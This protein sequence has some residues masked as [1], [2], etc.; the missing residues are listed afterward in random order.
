MDARIIFLIFA[1]SSCNLPRD[2]HH[3]LEKITK[4]HI[5]K[6]GTCS[7][8]SELEKNLLS[9]LAAQLHSTIIWT[10]DNQE[11]LYRYL[12]T[13]KI[14]VVA[15]EIEEDSP[16]VKKLSFTRS[17]YQTSEKHYVFAISQGENAWLTYF[18]QFIYG[19]RS[20]Q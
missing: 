6:V 10:T 12:E 9:M 8:T 1:L 4:S 2:P 19:Q 17:Y 11:T 3:T 5:V 18:N 20:H 15:C 16:W 7:T 14:D 13:R